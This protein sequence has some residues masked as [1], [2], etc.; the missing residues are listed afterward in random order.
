MT[1]QQMEQSAIPSRRSSTLVK[2]L[3]ASTA[4]CFGHFGSPLTA[5]EH[6]GEVLVN[7]SKD[8]RSLFVPL[9]KGSSDVSVAIVRRLTKSTRVPRKIHRRV[10]VAR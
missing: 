3:D 9:K 10:A 6:R 2:N 4:A 1:R 5:E 7:R 8:C